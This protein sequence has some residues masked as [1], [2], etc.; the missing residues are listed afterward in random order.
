MNNQMNKALIK[1]HAKAENWQEAGKLAG[2]LLVDNGY[3]K[4]PYI[5]KM[6]EVVEELGMYIVIAEGIAFFH[7]RPDENVLKTGLSLVTF[8]DGVNFGVDDKDPVYLAFALAAKDKVEHV[9]LLQLLSKRLR[10]QT[11]VKTLVEQDN[12]DAILTILNE[13]DE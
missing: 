12:E 8:K 2:Q 4:A 11:I 7:A 3:V 9:K 13:G 6:I 1:A 5:D 10:D